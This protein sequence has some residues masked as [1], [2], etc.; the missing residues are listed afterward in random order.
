MMTSFACPSLDTAGDARP[1]PLPCVPKH[2]ARTNTLHY[3][4]LPTWLQH[5]MPMHDAL[6]FAY[7]VCMHIVVV[8]PQGKGQ[9]QAD[10]LNV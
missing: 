9:S 10:N 8:R 4:A 1:S 5:R 3:T 7:S 2:T 6:G